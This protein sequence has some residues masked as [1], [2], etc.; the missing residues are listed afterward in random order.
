MTE[1]FGAYIKTALVVILSQH[2]LTSIGYSSLRKRQTSLTTANMVK[3]FSVDWLIQSDTPTNKDQESKDMSFAH[4]RPHVPCVVQPRQPSSF[5]KSYLQPKPKVKKSLDFN[6][7][8][9]EQEPVVTPACGPADCSS[10]ISEISG[11]SSGYESEAACSECP[12]VDDGLEAEREGAQRRVRTKFTPEQ[13]QKLEKIFSKHKYL[14]AGER[15]KTALKLNL[16]ET[17]V[18][19]WFQNR[20]MKVKRDVQDLRAEYLNPAMPTMIYP[21]VPS[22]QYHSFGAQQ[23]PFAPT[24]SM[25][26]SPMGQQLPVQQLITHQT[27]HPAMSA[28]YYY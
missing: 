13:I 5:D 23:I 6:D 17:Q 21:A 20:R 9:T 25:L 3:Y 24:A 2:S 27:I 8:H 12:S 18:R 14:D 22:V 1:G 28:A 26:Y 7:K 15:T 10:P 16:S 19:T 11:Y 4:F